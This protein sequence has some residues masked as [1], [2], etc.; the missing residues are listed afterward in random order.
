MGAN[1]LIHGRIH[2]RERADS[3][4]NESMEESMD[5]WENESHDGGIDPWKNEPTEEAMRRLW[6]EV[7]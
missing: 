6:R 5:P 3:W 7:F 4:K 1:E 2:G